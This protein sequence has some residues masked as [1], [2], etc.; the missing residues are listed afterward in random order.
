MM[1]IYSRS[2]LLLCLF[3]FL[4]FS[5]LSFFQGGNSPLHRACTVGH[6]KI[7]QMLLDA[8]SD[9]NYKDPVV[10][11]ALFSL[12]FLVSP[13]NISYATAD[14]WELLPVTGCLWRTF[15][16]RQTAPKTWSGPFNP[17]SSLLSFF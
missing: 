14:L 13:S 11:F 8:G 6:P 3:F 7:V 4:I 2:F 1:T 10:L 16:G 5:P 12:S 9:V 17:K 15:G